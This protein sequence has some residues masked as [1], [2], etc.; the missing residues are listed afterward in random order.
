MLETALVAA[1]DR[2]RLTEIAVILFRFGVDGLVKQLGLRQLIPHGQKQARTSAR[3]YSLPERLRFALEEL[4][5]TFIK[6][7]QILAT[8]HDLLAPEWTTEL[9]KLH[10][11][12]TPLPWSE[13]EKQLHDD[14]GAAPEVVFAQFDR[15][16][17]AS[18]SIAQVYR[19][20]LKSG[21]DVV[22]KIQR[23]K[24]EQTINADL[25]LLT[26]LAHLLQ[27][28]SKQWARFRPVDIVEYLARSMRSE[29]DFNNEGQNCEQIA[30]QFEGDPTVVIPKIYWQWSNRHLLVQDFIAGTEP[31]SAQQLREQGINPDEI[32]RRGALAM[33][34]M[35]LEY[36]QYHAD[37]HPGNLLA[38][39][40]NR[41]GFIDFGLVGRLSKKRKHQLLILLRALETGQ[42]EGVTA[43]LLEWSASFDADP[44]T[45][46]IAV[47]RFLADHHQPPLRIS[48]IL[49]DFMAMAR[50]L[51]ITLPPDLSLLFKT[52]ITADGVLKAI[53]ADIDLMALAR[54]MVEAQIKA[55]Y[56]P[57]AVRERG[58]Y[59]TSE[60]YDLAGEAPGFVRLLMH[61]IRHGRVGVDVDLRHIEQL[62]EALERAAARLSV[63]L[64]TA[65]FALGLAPHLLNQGPVFWGL[66]LFV[67]F[68][69]AATLAG[70]S[71][72]LYWLF[73]R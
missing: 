60:L 25:R 21:Q 67:W 55:Y 32:A 30:A 33:L 17:L 46:A 45:I 51:Q 52:F 29:L 65:A 72:L 63:A 39:S 56:S 61:R 69:L 44:V 73:K 28:N 66:P 5:P 59:V 9:S 22:V 11:H 64:V 24:L 19:A 3:D 50:Q 71:L 47:E 41:V 42:T 8:R 34:K 26:H 70:S 23:P 54:P 43:M 2:A 20:R 58:V 27:E 16:P 13:V 38:L 4:G 62:N 31:E 1:R 12:V 10:N 68:G 57:K 14:L 15:E 49:T 37:P 6:L 53:C 35:I 40:Q 36:G 48:L 7:G 18:A